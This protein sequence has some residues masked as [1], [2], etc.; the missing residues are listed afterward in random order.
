MSEPDLG[1]KKEPSEIMPPSGE[2]E[3]PQT[4]ET[5]NRAIRK[6][7][8]KGPPE[9]VTELIGMMETMSNPIHQKMNESH[10]TQVLELAKQ[11]DTNE[12]SLRKDQQQIDADAYR[13]DQNKRLVL[14]CILVA[15][16]LF[17][18]IAF[19]SQPAVLAP[20]LTGVGGVVTGFLAGTGWA[21]SHSRRR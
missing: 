2:R 4:G 6:L 12:F 9:E 7:A 17:I 3:Q 16:I 1:T 20:I 18:L 13:S 21:K 19:H 15:L 5:I 8:D 14:V 11:H 10:I